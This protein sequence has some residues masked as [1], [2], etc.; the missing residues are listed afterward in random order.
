MFRELPLRKGRKWQ[1]MAGNALSV[2]ALKFIYLNPGL[3]TV[4]SVDC[5]SQYEF[6]W[7]NTRMNP[8]G[9]H[10]QFILWQQSVV[11]LAHKYQE[12]INT[13]PKDTR[14]RGPETQGQGTQGQGTWVPSCVS[15]S[16]YDR[17]ATTSN[18]CQCSQC[19][20]H[21]SFAKADLYAQSKRAL[22]LFAWNFWP[23]D[24]GCS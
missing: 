11:M 4:L 23:W 22:R 24:L 10:G 15:L 9:C 19:S 21:I 8:L 12:T 13:W 1:E 18:L 7:S 3:T 5:A 16:F 2:L 20:L 17:T 14:T 6:G